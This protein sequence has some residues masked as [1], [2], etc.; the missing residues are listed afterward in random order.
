[1]QRK[2][3][4]P[5]PLVSEKHSFPEPKKNKKLLTIVKDK[6]SVLRCKNAEIVLDRMGSRFSNLT[7]NDKIIHFRLVW[8]SV[9][10]GSSTNNSRRKGLP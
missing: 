6:T 7:S 9:A 3:P 5:T 10:Y 8:F 2:Q 4:D 1:M